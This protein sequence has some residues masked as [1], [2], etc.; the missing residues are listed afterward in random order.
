[1]RR[2][3]RIWPANLRHLPHFS[4][5]LSKIAIRDGIVCVTK[6]PRRCRP[7]PLLRNSN[8][9]RGLLDQVAAL[10]WVKENISAFGG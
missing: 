7:L 3:C 1:M 10:H 2:P 6:L 8:A 9:N 5:D 4:H